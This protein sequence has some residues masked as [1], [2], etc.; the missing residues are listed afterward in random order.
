MSAMSNLP[1]ELM[2]VVLSH[3]GIYY[4][5]IGCDS[6][7]TKLLISLDDSVSLSLY[8]LPYLQVDRLSILRTRLEQWAASFE[9]RLGALAVKAQP[10]HGTYDNI[11]LVPC[12]PCPSPFTYFIFP[13]SVYQFLLHFNHFS[14]TPN[15]SYLQT[16]SMYCH[17]VTRIWPLL[18]LSFINKLQKFASTFPPFSPPSPL[19]LYPS[20]PLIVLRALLRTLSFTMLVSC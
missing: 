9:S 19:F 6:I 10:L 1:I 7:Y 18:L 15:F 2:H 11:P 16:R 20:L 3:F 8:S 17:R 14:S 13:R 5:L 12:D 4:S